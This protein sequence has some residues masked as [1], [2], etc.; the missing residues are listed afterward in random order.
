MA[1]LII[2]ATSQRV[3]KEGAQDER[4]HN[5]KANITNPS[6]ARALSA[7]PLLEV[8]EYPDMGLGTGYGDPVIIQDKNNIELVQWLAT[9]PEANT[10]Q[11]HK[12]HTSHGARYKHL[13]HKPGSW[14]KVHTP[15]A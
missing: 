8:N 7:H 3:L 6:T 10:Q 12:Y 14:S 4:V 2:N 11:Q 5:M 13:E 15:R 1:T 9:H